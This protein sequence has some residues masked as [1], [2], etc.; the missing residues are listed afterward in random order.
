MYLFN[1]KEVTE[2]LRAMEW[3]IAGGGTRLRPPDPP[4]ASTGM[5]P[6]GVDSAALSNPH[7]NR[8]SSQPGPAVPSP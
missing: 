7:E 6:G 2:R 1:L 5:S 8:P 4:L 3:A